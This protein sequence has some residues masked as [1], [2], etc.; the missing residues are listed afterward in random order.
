M[1]LRSKI[2]PLL[3]VFLLLIAIS[4]CQTA[5]FQG[6]L[7]IEEEETLLDQVRRNPNR[8]RDKVIL[9]GGE[10][11]GLRDLEWKT[12]IEFAELALDNEIHPRLGA[13]PRGRFYVVFPERVDKFLYKK[14]KIMTISGRLIGTRVIDG[15]A[16]PLLEFQEAQVWNRL[17]EDRFP[18]FGAFVGFF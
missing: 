4:G 16:Y 18:S 17:R 13:E 10:I 7:P 12:E 9:V 1:Y 3:A 14:G 2:G 5:Q 6:I 11:Q 15:E 8:H